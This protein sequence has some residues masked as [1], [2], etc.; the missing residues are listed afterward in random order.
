MKSEERPQK[1]RMVHRRF[2][3][4]RLSVER[5]ADAY[6]KIVPGSV[7]FLEVCRNTAN[8]EWVQLRP[9]IGGRHGVRNRCDLCPGIK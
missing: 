3:P 2:E 9:V 7:R 6:E 8:H 4:D 5:L 1:T